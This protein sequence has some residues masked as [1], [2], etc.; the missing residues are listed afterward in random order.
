[1]RGF[2]L[3]IVWGSLFSLSLKAQNA[4]SSGWTASDSL[5]LKRML[6]EQDGEVRIDRNMLDYIDFGQGVSGEQRMVTDKPWIEPD[7]S[8]PDIRNEEITPEM[9]QI[10]TLTPYKAST[11]YNWDPVYQ[12]KIK[13]DANTWRGDPFYKLRTTFRYSNRPYDPFAVG[14][15]RSLQDIED[16]GQKYQMFYERANNRMVGNWATSSGGAAVSGLD[17]MVILTRDFWNPKARKR[18]ARTLEV[19]QGYGDSVV[20][21]L[22]VPVQ[23]LE[24]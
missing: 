7:L 22:P 5:K 15:R 20:A 14:E 16:T 9:R 12:R 23:E 19:L 11:P 10:L 24:K 8:L 4:E 2:V 3:W 21:K 17:F 13:I 1:M 6:Q 18:R